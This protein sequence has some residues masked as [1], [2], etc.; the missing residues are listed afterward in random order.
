MQS[1]PQNH[2]GYAIR[3]VEPDEA[4][5]R[6]LRGAMKVAFKRAFEDVL[7]TLYVRF[8]VGDRVDD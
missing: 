6:G 4:T 8:A 5:T 1:L 7:W 2:P 3:A